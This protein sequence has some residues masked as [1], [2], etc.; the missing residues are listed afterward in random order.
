M[1]I[2]GRGGP[3]APG[4]GRGG[5]GG[6]TQKKEPQPLDL[7]RGLVGVSWQ[8]V[9][10]HE[11]L[12]TGRVDPQ[13]LPQ[14]PLLDQILHRPTFEE[15]MFLT[16]G[17]HTI[18]P[19]LLRVVIFRQTRLELLHFFSRKRDKEKDN[20]RRRTIFAKAAELLDQD[21]SFDEDVTGKMAALVQA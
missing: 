9:G 7:E 19:E 6:A 18:D 2:K 8:K 15:R 12:P 21:E 1:S 13:F 5:A 3:S 16:L 11:P 17:L 10:A 20:E 14:R 4:T